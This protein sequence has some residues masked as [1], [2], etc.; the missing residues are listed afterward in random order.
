MTNWYSDHEMRAVLNCYSFQADRVSFE[1]IE[2]YGYPCIYCVKETVNGSETWI[3]NDVRVQD[4]K[5]IIKE[6]V[7]LEYIEPI[8]V[9]GT[10]WYKLT[11]KGREFA[12]KR[13]LYY[14]EASDHRD[15]RTEKIEGHN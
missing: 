11:P 5:S 12:G 15:P 2:L 8:N 6:L 9:N 10:E 3:D 13:Y 1:S 4:T 7:R 14:R